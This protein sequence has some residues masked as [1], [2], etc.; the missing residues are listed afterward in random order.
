MVRAYHQ[1]PVAADDIKK[2][3]VITPFGLFEYTRMP[4]GLRCAAQTFQRVIDTILRGLPFAW[5]YLDDLLVASAT[6]EE[7]QDHLRAVFARL[8][9]AGMRL[10]LAKCVLGTS[11]LTFLGHTVS[12]EGVKP[13]SD[14][15]DAIRAFPL[16]QTQKQLRQ[17]LGMVNFYHRFLRSASELLRPLT[18]LITQKKR[19]SAIILDWTDEARKA[20][21]ASKEALAAATL[22]VHP[23]DSAPT[24]IQVDASDFAVGG[25]LQ[26]Y[27]NNVWSPLALFSRKL[28]PAETRYS[29]FGRELLAMYLATRH[30]RYF[31]EGRDFHIL[32]DHKP[33]T[34]A[35]ISRH[36]RH[37]PREAR[38]LEYVSQFTTDV[39]HISGVDNTTA[40]ALSRIQIDSISPIPIIDFEAMAQLQEDEI[41]DPTLTSSLRLEWITLPG[42][43]RKLLCDTSTST[44]RPYVPS[45]YRKDIFFNLHSL[46]HPGI[47]ASRKL[48]SARFVWPGVNA[49]VT[50]WTRNCLSCQRSK[51]QR[52][53]KSPLGSFLPPGD[54]FEKVHIDIVGPL[55][56][57]NGKRY[58]LTCIDRFTRWTEAIPLSVASSESI[59]T[60]F[61]THWVSRF[62]IPCLL[63]TSDAA[64]ERS[65]VD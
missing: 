53:T 64:D 65:S 58:L 39:R 32:T 11:S 45:S 28:Q 38:H 52:H 17:Y 23:Q 27:L 14:R 50:K 54:R 47:E 35:M 19:G 29:A 10:N 40:D 63:Y 62:G 13:L 4:F 56:P 30:F 16:P 31:I 25:V 59:T 51:V 49:D 18:A 41:I 7:H 21:D 44:P 37:S 60:A 43:K 2:T 48:V 8:N 5:A 24:R 26:Q 6:P 36:E 9:D 61:M 46:S 12:P 1:I 3:A 55:P 57:S 22:L 33:L 20:F 15:V 42:I 34:F